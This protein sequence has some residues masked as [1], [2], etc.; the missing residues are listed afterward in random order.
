MEERDRLAFEFVQSAFDLGG[1][2]DED[3]GAVPICIGRIEYS[4]EDVAVG[5]GGEAVG[6]GEDRNLVNRGLGDE[7]QGDAG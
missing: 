6:H 3:A 2:F 7:L 4:G 1:V 5:G